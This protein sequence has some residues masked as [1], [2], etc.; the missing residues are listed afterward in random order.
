MLS[1]LAEGLNPSLAEGS[2]V[3][4]TVLRPEI[5]ETRVTKDDDVNVASERKRE[6][7]LVDLRRAVQLR[8]EC[9]CVLQKHW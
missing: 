8:L 6:V 9:H 5:L 7:T 2:Y 4:F 3:K 1:K